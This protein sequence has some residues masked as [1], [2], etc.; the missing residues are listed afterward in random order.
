MTKEAI[1][2]NEEKV[3]FSVN[4]VEKRMN[5]DNVLTPYTKINS[6]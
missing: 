4:S 5:S 1:T 6:K 3:I 2:H